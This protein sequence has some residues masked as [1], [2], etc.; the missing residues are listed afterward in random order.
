MNYLSGFYSVKKFKINFSSV[1]RKTGYYLSRFL[2][3]LLNEKRGL[4]ICK[5]VLL[6]QG[7]NEKNIS[8]WLYAAIQN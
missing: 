8:E 4:H 3:A 1:L 7:F 6:S 2:R 5:N